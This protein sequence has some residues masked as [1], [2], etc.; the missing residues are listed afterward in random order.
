MSPKVPSPKDDFDTTQW[1]VVSNVANHS[2]PVR[3]EALEQLCQT[4]WRPLF[5]YVQRRTDNIEEAQDLTQ[6][7]FCRLLEKDNFSNAQPEFGRF[8]AFLL[9]A[10]NH[11]LANE[12]KKARAENI[13]SWNWLRVCSKV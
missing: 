3:R 5:S 9:A 2:W 1:N 13:S 11:F 7:F 4:Y 6:E 12:W 8:R 10:M